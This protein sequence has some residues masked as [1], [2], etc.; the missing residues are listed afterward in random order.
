[1]ILRAAVVV[2][3]V[4][5]AAACGSAPD[6]ASVPAPAPVPAPIEP[7]SDE[8][9]AGDAALTT[10][11]QFWTVA[12]QALNAPT[13]RD[14]TTELEAVASGQALESLLAD[15]EN[16]A[17]Y[18]AH[19]EGTVERAPTIRSATTDSV[20][21]VDCVDMTDYLLIADE[22]GEVLTDTANQVPRFQFHAQVEQ[23]QPGRW[24]VD[25]TRPAWDEPC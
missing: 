20:A 13:S 19:N 23:A 2:V 9:R 24:L 15:I 4:A 3:L 10:Y 5:V 12:E 21:I 14:W 16:Y 18:P 7:P 8:A 1:M 6:P 11:N 25:R 22:T 17:A